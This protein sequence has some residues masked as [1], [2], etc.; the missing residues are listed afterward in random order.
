MLSYTWR[1]QDTYA[2]ISVRNTTYI[3]HRHITNARSCSITRLSSPPQGRT[4]IPRLPG[5]PSNYNL[6]VFT[7][8][9]PSSPYHGEYH[10]L[11]EFK[12][13]RLPSPP[14]LVF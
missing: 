3:L 7:L 4:S 2:R 6:P 14:A 9:L 11:M 1:G 5:G 8:H 12:T 13:A 10:Q